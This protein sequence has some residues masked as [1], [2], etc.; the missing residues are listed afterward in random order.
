MRG[1]KQVASVLVAAVALAGIPALPAVAGPPGYGHFHPWAPG[2]GLVGAVVG[3][4][5]LPLAIAAATIGAVESVPYAAGYQGA[6]A[7]APPPA[8]YAAPRPYYATPYYP[9]PPVYYSAPRG[10]YGPP[11][12]YAARPGYNYSYG[13][14]PYR[15]SGYGYAHR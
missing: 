4:A 6:P 9:R 1:F 2:R 8:S 3:L 12:Y 10:Y 13:R 11:G 7:Y 15:A 5:T 14:G